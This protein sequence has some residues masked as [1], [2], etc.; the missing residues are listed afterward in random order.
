MPGVHCL[1][2]VHYCASTSTTSMSPMRNAEIRRNAPVV[3]TVPRLGRS[4]ILY[5]IVPNWRMSETTSQKLEIILPETRSIIIR[6]KFR[7]MMA[8]FK[9][10][11]RGVFGPGPD[12]PPRRRPQASQ[13]RHFNYCIV[14]TFQIPGNHHASVRNLEDVGG[15]DFKLDPDSE[16]SM[17]C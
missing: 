12:H 1:S 15:S 13:E 17:K 7:V 6:V 10:V 2:Q 16:R 5:L 11:E 14:N 4:L 8:S 9:F 3:E